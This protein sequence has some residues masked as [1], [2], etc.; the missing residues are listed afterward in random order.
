[1]TSISEFFT[2]AVAEVIDEKHL[3]ARLE[4]GE[5]LRVKFGV[6][7]TSPHLHLGR[8]V[9]ILKLRDLQQMGHQIVFIVGDFTGVIGDT[10][11]KESERP[12]LTA[13]QVE[14][15]MQA[16]FEQASKI[17]D[18]SLVEKHYNTEWLEHLTYRE[19]SV[20]ADAFSVA[21]FIAR[22]NIRRRIDSGKR[23]SLREILYPLM[24]GYDSV[25]VRA[26]LEIGGT[27]QRFN[28]LAGRTLQEKYGQKPQDVMMVNLIP[29]LDGRKMSSSWGNTVNLTDVPNDMFGKIMS[30]PDDLIGT[31]FLHVT[32][33]SLNEIQE[34]TSD[35][36]NKTLNPR[37]AKLRLAREIVN[38]YCGV[39]AGME[40]ERFFVETFSKR[41][42][43]QDNIPIY[44]VSS[45]T[46]LVEVLVGAGLAES[47]T[48]ARRKILQGAVSSDGKKITEQNTLVD[49]SFAMKILKVGKHG[50]VKI[51]FNSSTSV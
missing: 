47:K 34:I 30:I 32:R 3:Q 1:M 22:D 50:F 48:D 27:D 9:P 14:S 16:Y 4:S 2:R 28:L 51:V 41:S 36:E 5:K 26:D 46:L 12:M 24:Q 10:S 13:D 45:P 20:Q 39:S 11:D 6:D 40:A 38:I 19:I 42:V 29:G 7:P 35:M 33:V 18:M 31:Y 8:S 17:L 23:V 44:A 15:N 37:D 49:E 21:E 25:I 43:P